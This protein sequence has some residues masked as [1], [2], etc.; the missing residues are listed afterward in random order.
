MARCRWPNTLNWGRDTSL[1]TPTEFGPSFH[2][3]RISLI[4]YPTNYFARHIFYV[5]M[6][7]FYSISCLNLLDFSYY[8]C[9]A[10]NEVFFFYYFIYFA[11]KWM[12]GCC[13]VLA[14][15]IGFFV[16]KNKLKAN[17]LLVNNQRAF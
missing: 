11:Q 2:L 4:V 7:F 14:K 8:C 10:T 13:E 9:G 3:Y 1:D 17:N 16:G 6:G 12:I 15:L 5:C